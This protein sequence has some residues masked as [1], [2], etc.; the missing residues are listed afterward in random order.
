[1]ASQPTSYG[2]S[3][4]NQPS[5]LDLPL[6]IREPLEG[7]LHTKRS[8]VPWSPA[9]MFFPVERIAHAR[10]VLVLVL[11]LVLL[12]LLTWSALDGVCMLPGY[13]HPDMEQNVFTGGRR[14][15]R[16]HWMG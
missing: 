12:R 9:L 7:W 1:M 11:V 15:R 6:A 16:E 14:R 4:R 2:Y 3:G 5:S 8:A 10:E 13:C